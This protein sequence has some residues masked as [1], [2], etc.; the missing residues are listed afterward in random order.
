MPPQVEDSECGA[1]ATEAYGFVGWV[2]S[3]A[4]YG[5]PTSSPK[6]SCA[7]NESLLDVILKAEMLFYPL[8]CGSTCQ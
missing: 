4:A 8:F 3:T 6:E 1:N 5:A 7:Y 2:T